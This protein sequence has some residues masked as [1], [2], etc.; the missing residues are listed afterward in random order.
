MKPTVGWWIV[1]LA[2]QLNITFHY[3]CWY[4]QTSKCQPRTVVIV[5]RIV[6][7]PTVLMAFSDKQNNSIYVCCKH[8]CQRTERTGQ[9]WPFSPNPHFH[10]ITQGHTLFTSCFQSITHNNIDKMLISVLLTGEELPWLICF[11]KVNGALQHP[12]VRPGRVGKLD[13]HICNMEK[14]EK[15]KRI[16]TEVHIWIMSYFHETVTTISQLGLSVSAISSNKSI[17]MTSPPP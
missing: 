9:T 15:I 13:E 12:Q 10:S 8:K 5:A 3:A 4:C 16:T 14:L 7:P 2:K 6:L 17:L 1:S 11:P